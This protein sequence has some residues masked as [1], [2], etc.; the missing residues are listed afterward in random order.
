MGQHVISLGGFSVPTPAVIA[1]GIYVIAMLYT[2][3]KDAV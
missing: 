1:A 3:R 2:E